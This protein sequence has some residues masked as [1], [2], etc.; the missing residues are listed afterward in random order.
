MPVVTTIN[1]TAGDPAGRKIVVED[2]N[3]NS[4]PVANIAWAGGLPSDVTVSP[5]ADGI[6]F[7]FLAAASAPAGTVSTSA[8]YT[9][10]GNPNPVAGPMLNIIVASAA[11]TVTGLQYN[12]IGPGP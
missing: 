5:A 1:L 10:P 7:L 4:L 8:T 11:P 2:Q 3:S 9:G 12:D 6:S